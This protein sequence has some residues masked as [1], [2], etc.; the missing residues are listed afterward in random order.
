MGDFFASKNTIERVTLPIR[1]AC[2]GH[3]EV[4]R[5]GNSSTWINTEDWVQQYPQFS[6]SH[7][8][9]SKSFTVAL[10]SGSR[11]NIRPANSVNSWLWCGKWLWG[12]SLPPTK[13]LFISAILLHHLSSSRCSKRFHG[14][15]PKYWIIRSMTYIKRSMP[16]FG[17][18]FVVLN[19]TIFETA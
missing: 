14:T 2:Y 16:S 3:I 15:G 17:S 11:S 5:L 13:Q 19:T 9:S 6:W 1:T 4:W 10:F 18:S 12:Q 8:G 7:Q